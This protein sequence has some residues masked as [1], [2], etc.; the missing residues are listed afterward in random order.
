MK[1]V[2]SGVIFLGAALCAVTAIAQ[3]IGHAFDFGQE[4]RMIDDTLNRVEAVRNDSHHNFGGHA[5]KAETLLRQ[6]K[7]EL[8]A[9]AE[10]GAH[11]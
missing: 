3:P 2:M 6:A 5:A 7:A 1:R 10:Y 8:N 11:H 4:Q 9:A